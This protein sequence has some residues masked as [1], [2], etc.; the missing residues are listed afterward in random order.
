MGAAGA[1]LDL[2]WQENLLTRNINVLCSSWLVDHRGHVCTLGSRYFDWE[3]RIV[4]LCMRGNAAV[5]C[6]SFSYPRGV[7]V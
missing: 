7:G 1:L 4:P 6:C 3:C 5:L 2:H